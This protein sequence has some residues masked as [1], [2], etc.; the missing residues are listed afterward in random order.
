MFPYGLVPWIAGA[1]LYPAFGDWAVTLLM[2]AGVVAVIALACA[3]RPAMRDPWLLSIFVLNPFFVDAVLV[4]QFSFI[5]AT[6]FFFLFV[7]A[8]ERRRWFFGAALLFLAVT[9]HP[10]MGGAAVGAYGI[11]ALLRWRRH[12]VALL[13]SMAAGAAAS[14]PFIWMT[15]QTPSLGDNSATTVILS[16]LDILPRRGLV[17]GG[18]FLLAALAVWVRTQYRFALAIPVVGLVITVPLANGAFGYAQG[19]Y[20]GLVRDPEGMYQEFLSSPG[21]EAGAVYRVLEPNQR[22]DGMYDFMR[23]GAVL[24]SEFFTESTFRRDFTE[25]QYQCF[26]AV[27][28]TDYVAVETA[29]IAQYDVNELELLRTLES[30]GLV[31]VTHQ[32]PAERFTVFDVRRFR[33]VAPAP[34]SLIDCRL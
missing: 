31:S 13:L 8:V 28:A 23:A 34:V 18:P 4:F 3:V 7:M 24:S 16:V 19:S 22:E 14:A 30:R 17:I 2:V 25:P 20:E 15:L 27:K 26:L 11:Y 21:F 29:Y 9:T 1:L 12:L 32:E 33:G 10:I 6:A 5:W